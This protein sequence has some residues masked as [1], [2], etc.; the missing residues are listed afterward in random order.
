VGVIYLVRHGQALATAYGADA[1]SPELGG[2]TDL[3]RRQATRAGKS[4]AER[5]DT[6]SAALSGVIARQCETL[7]R[8]LAE[9]P[10][11]QQ[12]QRDSGWNEYDMAGILGGERAVVPA[13]R[14]M[15]AEI[16][17]ALEQWVAG[18][19]GGDETYARFRDRCA[20]A[21]DSA[22]AQ[23][24]SGRTVVVASSAGTIAQVVATVL[25]IDG[26][27][28]IRLSRTMINASV[29]K[30]IVG[31]GGASVVSVNEHAHLDVADAAGERPLMTFR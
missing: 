6:V 9:L 29:T 26:P 21:L 23:A 28:W 7:D 25:R 12:P 30:L 17:T 5:V 19:D 8:V 18:A 31:R 1:E 14:E 24:G 22:A 3:G 4:L 20:A 10:Y 11:D 2:L 16:D 13:G 15:Q 27:G